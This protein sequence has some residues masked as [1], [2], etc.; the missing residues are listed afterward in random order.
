MPHKAALCII[1]MDTAACRNNVLGTSKI[2]F[3]SL[4]MST[5]IPLIHI[6]LQFCMYFLIS[7]FIDIGICCKAV[8]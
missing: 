5:I 1:I 3:S 8:L 4:E 6:S 7:D 2:S